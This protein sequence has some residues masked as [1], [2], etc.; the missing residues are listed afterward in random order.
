MKMRYHGAGV[1][2]GVIRRSS[3]VAKISQQ[4]VDLKA[5]KYGSPAEV[6]MLTL[7]MNEANGV[8]IRT[9]GR[10]DSSRHGES[11]RQ[12]PRHPDIEGCMLKKN[13]E[14]RRCLSYESS[15]VAL[16]KYIR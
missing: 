4:V 8:V 11:R 16:D 12:V 10:Q 1:N 2:A 9:S 6:A 15:L 13:R 5:R 14:K 3:P 7:E